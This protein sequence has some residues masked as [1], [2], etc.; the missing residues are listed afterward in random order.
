MGLINER[1]REWWI[2]DMIRH[3]SHKD[4]AEIRKRIESDPQALED[5]AE[6]RMNYEQDR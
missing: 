2:N 1:D 6:W 3:Y 4:E 5:Y